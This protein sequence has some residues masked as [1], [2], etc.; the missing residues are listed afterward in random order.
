MSNVVGVRHRNN[1]VAV[2]SAAVSV[3]RR[4]RR[5][6]PI[7]T[8]DELAIC[9]KMGIEPAHYLATRHGI[10][11]VHGNGNLT[12]RS[13]DE[14][15]QMLRHTLEI[16]EDTSVAE[17]L[18]RATEI[19]GAIDGKSPDVGELLDVAAL[20]VEA[21]ERQADSENASLGESDD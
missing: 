7:I 18:A 10:I 20:L 16:D 15:R 8:A 13:I 17:L 14:A 11:S 2:M 6:S 1:L 9:R 19:L 4:S 21:F 5:H 12:A 3:I